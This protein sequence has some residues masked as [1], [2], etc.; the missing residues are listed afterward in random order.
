[1]SGTLIS[2]MRQ[3]AAGAGNSRNLLLLLFIMKMKS[4]SKY[5]KCPGAIPLDGP[6]TFF[7]LY[8]VSQ[9]KCT[10]LSFAPCQI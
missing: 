8:T 9:Q 7:Y 4:Y 1:M 6:G 10:N 5:K 2:P 3:S